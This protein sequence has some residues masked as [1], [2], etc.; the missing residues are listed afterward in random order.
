MSGRVAVV[1]SLMM[2]LVVRAPRLPLAGESL[3]GRSFATF[4][5]GKGGNQAIA[6]ARAG[7]SEVH[8]IGRVGADPFGEE[9]VRT[10]EHDRVNCRFVSLD[11]GAGT[12][13]AVPIVF[14]DGTNSIIAVPRA[15]LR[16]SPVEIMAAQVVLTSVDVLL[17]QFE[18]NMEAIEVAMQLA[19]EAGVR[20][21]LNPAP[22]APHRAEVFRRAHVVVANEVE[23]AALAPECGGDHAA[24][25]LALLAKGPA[26]AI[27]TLGT[28][29]AIVATQ[30]ERLFIPA[31]DVE[32]LDSVGAGDAFCGALAVGLCERMELTEAVRFASAAGALA[33]TKAGAAASLPVRGAIDELCGRGPG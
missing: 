4:V 21:I 16:M 3:I 11:A 25:A 29:G 27:V 17:V 32:A 19:R 9:I 31:F 5:G 20:V 8:M 28:E 1:G 13:V 23:A 22:I 33:V 7:A 6:A 2:D 10:L 12:G 14:D 18:I 30:E 24:E 26:V 15:N